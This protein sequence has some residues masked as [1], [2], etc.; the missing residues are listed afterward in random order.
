MEKQLLKLA[1]SALCFAV[2]LALIVVDNNVYVRIITLVGAYFTGW[3][4]CYTIGQMV[5]EITK[6]NKPT[7]K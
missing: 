4:T 6:N 3:A 5:G 7:C 1:V 2:F